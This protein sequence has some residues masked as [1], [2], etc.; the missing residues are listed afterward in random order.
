MSRVQSSYIADPTME[1]PVGE[2]CYFCIVRRRGCN[3]LFYNV[4]VHMDRTDCTKMSL[5]TGPN[6]SLLCITDHSSPDTDSHGVLGWSS[7]VER[8][9][10][11][12]WVVHHHAIIGLT[13]HHLGLLIG[14][15]V[16]LGGVLVGTLLMLLLL[17]LLM[18]RINWRN[19]KLL[20]TK[21]RCMKGL[22]HKTTEFPL[23]RVIHDKI[24]FEIWKKRRRKRTLKCNGLLWSTHTTISIFWG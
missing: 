1:R 19:I 24:I 9:L 17:L 15:H 12:W 18:V 21:T 22:Q 6:V 3:L 11:G 10:V 23:K 20:V 7:Q 4:A 14:R 5:S 8:L 2:K 13:A 16:A